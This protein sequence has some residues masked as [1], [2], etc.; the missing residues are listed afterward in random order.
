MDE[1]RFV[2]DCAL[3][4]PWRW[5]ALQAVAALELPEAWI[6]AGFVRAPVWDRLHGKTEAT[7]LDDLDVIYFDSADLDPAREAALEA[8]LSATLPGHSWQVRNQARMHLRNGDRPY[9]SAADA[10]AHW[11]ETPTAVA[12]R[13]E[14]GQPHLLAPLG[15]D[16]LVSLRLCPTPHARRHR[17]AAYR[18]RVAGKDWLARWP[19][20]TV[21]WG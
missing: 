10:L 6:G 3:E 15:L 8:R 17:L 19:R 14:A 21:D 1:R 16:D 9:C 20:I 12:L 18:E 4:A 2:L 11:L 7:P 5:A 13:L